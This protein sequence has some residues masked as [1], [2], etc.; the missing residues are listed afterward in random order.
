MR[1]I[2]GIYDKETTFPK[3]VNEVCNFFQSVELN[4]QKIPAQDQFKTRLKELQAG[5]KVPVVIFNCLDFKWGEDQNNYP[6]SIILEN[7]DTSICKYFSSNI[8]MFMNKLKTLGIPQLNIIIPD[9]ELFDNRPF[10]FM[11]DESTRLQIASTVYKN[12]SEELSSIDITFAGSVVL[13]SKYCKKNNL[14]S[15]FKYTSLNID[16]IRRDDLLMQKVKKQ[17]KDS[18]KYFIARGLNSNYVETIEN[19]MLD[20]TLAYLAMY[21]GEGQA[22][23]ESCAIVINLEDQ[24]VSA[25]FQR[26]AKDQ[27]PI[28]TPVNSKEFYNWRKNILL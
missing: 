4:G 2:Q 1:E 23:A 11:Q 12:L 9:S 18:K 15:P 22:L 14:S 19:E 25:W 6:K 16:R 28:L 3:P 7:T 20:K 26:G 13:W 27:L 10:S 24:R 5:R 17:A 21:A 8:V